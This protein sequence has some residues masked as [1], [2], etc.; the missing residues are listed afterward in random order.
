MK[1]L[2][3]KFPN[4]QG[5]F[6][7]VRLTIVIMRRDKVS[8]YTNSFELSE[9]CSSYQKPAGFHYQKL[10][11]SVLAEPFGFSILPLIPG[12]STGHSAI[13]T[14]SGPDSICHLLA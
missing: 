14:A 1:K 4:L 3:Y 5:A 2:C 10:Y 9:N 12:L 11:L 13:P 8:D 7:I 6:K